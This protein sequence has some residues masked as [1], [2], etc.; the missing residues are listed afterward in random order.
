MTVA[1]AGRLG[2]STGACAAAAAKAAALALANRQEAPVVIDLPGGERATLP[3]KAVRAVDRARAWAEVVKDAGDDPDTTNGVIVRVDLE[4]L[5]N[6]RAGGPERE[7]VPEP[8]SRVEF[9]AG[10]GVGTVTR[11]GLQLGVGEPAINPVPRAMIADALEEVLGDRRCRVTVSI[12]G[13]AALA[14]RTFNPRLG[15]VGGLSVLGT[16]GR[17]VPRSED[18]WLRSL[19]PQVDVAL[20]SGERTLY[21]AP[22]GF[23]E[24]V[25]QAMLGASEA[26]VIRCSN[27][28][29]ALLDE[30]A[31]KGAERVVLVGHVG[32]LVKV[33]AGIFDTHSRHGDARLETVAALAGAAGAPAGLVGRLLDLPTVEAAVPVLQEAGLEEVWDDIA[34]RAASRSLA[35]ALSAASEAGTRPP[36]VDCVLAG[37][38]ETVIGRS[39]RL[40]APAEPSADPCGCGGMIT[41]VGVGPGPEDLMTS[42][43]WHALRHAQVVVG[44]SRQLAGFAAPGAEQIVVGTDMDGL[45]ADIRSRLDRRIVVL[46]S[47]DPTCYGILSTLTRRFSAGE[48][49]VVPGVSSLQLALARLRMSWES[50]VFA[51]THGKDLTEVLTAIRQHPRV[52]ALT[53]PLRGPSY[54]A[55]ALLDDSLEG[56]MTVFE[57]LGYPDE[58]ITQGSFG[59]IAL[60]A[61]GPL[62]V[63]LVEN[64]SAD[65]RKREEARDGAQ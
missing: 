3:V 14:E 54:V 30:C 59:E 26:S 64:A 41:V 35:R 57:R 15:I 33:A 62:S 61:F 36:L 1:P 53:D 29:G 19:V 56:N 40:R 60:V 12:P 58:H 51:S 43:G 32:K 9:V 7:S 13:G 8:R 49:R 16:S 28:L 45:E 18:A 65:G 46:A 37:Y 17:V 23:G 21:L 42:A 47:G 22:G 34:D 44:G 25:A 31:K 27:F 5:D 20:A 38:G 6:K 48:L 63:V 2:F 24:R 4:L 50:V 11:V 55:A 52:L 10:A 39:Q